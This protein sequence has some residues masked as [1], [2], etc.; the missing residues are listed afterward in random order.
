MTRFRIVV[1]AACTAL[2]LAAPPLWAQSADVIVRVERTPG[3]T[4]LSKS[5]NWV[6]ITV[7]VVD[8]ATGAPPRDDYNVV[9]LARNAA[10]EETEAYGCGQRSDNNVGVPRGIYDCVVIVDH[11]GSW[12]FEGVVN[13]VPVGNAPKVTLARG[14]FTMDVEAGALAGLAPKPDAI[15][16]QPREVVLLGLH[17]AFAG[18]WGLCV[19]LLVAVA[20]PAARRLLSP[21]ALHRLEDRLGL[22]TRLA[23][24]STALVAGTGLYLLLNQTAYETP[25][26][27]SAVE[28]VFRLPYGRPYF[29]TLGVKLVVYALMVLGLLPLILEARRRS[30]LAGD[31]ANGIGPRTPAARPAS[32]WAITAPAAATGQRGATATLEAPAHSRLAVTSAQGRP[33]ASG[34][35]RLGAA[36]MVVG[37]PTI[38]GCVTVLKYLH[39]FVEASRAVAR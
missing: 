36:V 10:G 7:I 6:P 8:R 4:T 37:G 32:P 38:L 25:W 20:L 5:P 31:Q 15:R 35:A 26:S 2:V 33:G 21:T 19:A 13:S 12:T 34:L 16:A 3:E 39:E 23:M 24:G 29:L 30:Q 18:V 28:G 1:G 14:S 22:L 17:S 27:P 11:G 9:A